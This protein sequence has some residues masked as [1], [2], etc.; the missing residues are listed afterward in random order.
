MLSLVAIFSY[1]HLFYLDKYKAG[2]AVFE[3]EINSLFT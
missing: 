3:L 2:K 1:P